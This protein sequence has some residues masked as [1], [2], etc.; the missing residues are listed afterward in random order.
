[1]IFI[2]DLTFFPKFEIS[3]FQIYIHGGGYTRGTAGRF[4]GHSFIAAA[5][6]DVILVTINYRLFDLGFLI[7]RDES[8]RGNILKK[9]TK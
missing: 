2:F 3:N 4:D 7:T 1:M 6:G 9:K 5:G 8:V